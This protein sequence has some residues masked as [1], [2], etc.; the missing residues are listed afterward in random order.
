M[1]GK[2]KEKARRGS[3]R[4][5]N[6]SVKFAFV[7]SSPRTSVLL[8]AIPRR[9][10]EIAFGDFLLAI[11]VITNHQIKPFKSFFKARYVANMM[12]SFSRE[13]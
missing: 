10:A 6:V 7:L 4:T 12:K 3:R 13:V 1:E 9:G 8:S 5:T 2:A 11:A